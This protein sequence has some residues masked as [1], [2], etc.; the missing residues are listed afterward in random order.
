VNPGDPNIDGKVVYADVDYCST[1]GNCDVLD[2]DD[3][4]EQG[5]ACRIVNPVTVACTPRGS[6]DVGEDCADNN[7]CGAGMHCV[8]DLSDPENPIPPKCR[9]FCPFGPCVESGCAPDEKCVHFPND[10]P[11]VGECTPDWN[12]PPAALDAGSCG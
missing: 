3:C 4:S 9:K 11:G 6:L 1:V 10:P 12:G 5:R 2:V 8:A 7:K